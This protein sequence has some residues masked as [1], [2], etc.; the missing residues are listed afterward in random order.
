[1]LLLIPEV[2]LQQTGP[3]PVITLSGG[4]HLAHSLQ[5]IISIKRIGSM[6]ENWRTVAHELPVLVHGRRLLWW[7]LR[8]VVDL[9]LQIGHSV[10][11]VLQEL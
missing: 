11:Q 6:G 8:R 7:W 10:G 3:S 9:G 5:P 2:G 1:M 4:E